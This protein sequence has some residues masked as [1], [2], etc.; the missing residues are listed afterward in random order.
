M[1]LF[2]TAISTPKEIYFFS[3]RELKKVLRDTLTRAGINCYRQRPITFSLVR[4]EHAH[5]SYP[6]L[7]F[8]SARVQPL[9]VAERKESTGTGLREAM[10]GSRKPF[11]SQLSKLSSC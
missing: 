3:A 10:H 8:S 1:N 2:F 5:A 11:Q 6:G 4:F 9:Y 7:F